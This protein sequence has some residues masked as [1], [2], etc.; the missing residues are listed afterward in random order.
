M[1]EK[2][3]WSPI[4]EFIEEANITKFLKWLREEK[5]LEFSDYKSLR[6]WSTDY[7]EDFWEIIVEYF[8]IQFH[9]P[10]KKV[11]NN[12]KMPGVR[13]FEGATLNYT[14]QVFKNCTE[15]FPALI[16]ETETQ[17]MSEM[18]WAELY[19]K[20]ASVSRFMRNNNIKKGDRVVAFM[21]NT[22]ETVVAFLA[23]ASIGAVW[24]SCSPEFGSESVIERFKQIKPKMMFAVDGGF[25]M[26]KKIDK[27]DVISEIL[28]EIP[29]IETLVMINYIDPG[30]EIGN[31]IKDKINFEEV[32]KTKANK[33]EYNYVEFNDPLWVLYS[34]GTTGK[35]KA[36]TQS[37]GG[38][39]LEHTKYLSLHSNVKPGSR[40]FWYSTTGWM[41]WNFLMGSL[42]VGG[43]AVLYDGSPTYPDINR[44]WDLAE[45]AK[46]ETFGT[47]AAYIMACIKAGIIP[48]ETH[49][50][51]NLKSIGSTGSPLPVAGFKW[52][53]ENVKRDLW[54]NSVSGGTD[55]CSV[56]TGGLPT[57]PV[58]PGE[59]QCRSLAAKVESFD[60]NGI[61][62]EGR[63]GEMVITE[64]MPSMPI[65][66]WNDENFKRYT[67]SYFEMYPDKWRHGDWIEIT[68]RGGAIISGRSDSTLNR[69]GIRIGTAEI[70]SAVEKIPEVK[71]SLIIGLEREGGK[72]YLP[73]FV[74]LQE[75]L[76][77][78]EALIKK[79]NTALRKQFSPRHVPDQVFQIN[80]VPYTLSGKKME[81]PVKKYFRGGELDK[82]LNKDAMRNPESFDYFI[83]FKTNHIDKLVT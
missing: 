5:H 59:I 83:S 25:Y 29:E 38:I 2:A 6:K 24:S 79:I 43:T 77:L 50:L 52:C 37:Q 44:L 66:F 21:P 39:V 19:K 76:I 47:S 32:L 14:E 70:Y 33:I 1:L 73:L 74:V 26:G 10:Y 67:D 22:T 80:E 55:I 23:T 15:N 11:L 17:P 4:S 53:Y 7:I 54:L 82:I 71:D 49:D 58:Y 27:T 18:S 64:P 9:H 3:L 65:Y 41:M 63:V 81:T 46:I 57:L 78:N 69:G 42:L 34:S 60:D 48:K 56:F 13:W 16:S 75:G 72:Y 40:F 20:V 62:S 31:K 35:P 45:K 30:G 28:N 68:E 8:N 51:S 36:I 12:H 61:H